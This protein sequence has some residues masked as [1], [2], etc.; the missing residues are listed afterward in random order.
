MNRALLFAG[1]GAQA[2]G[3]GKELAE[4]YPSCRALFDEASDVLGYDLATLC[5]EGPEDL[6]TRSDHAQPA[7]FVMSAASFLALEQKVANPVFSVSAGLS[8]GEWTALYAAGVLSFSDTVSLLQARGRFMQ[9]ACEEEPGGMLTLIGL[10][11]PQVMTIAEASGLEVANL[12][13]PVQTVLSGRKEYIPVAEQ[14][15]REAGAKR[16]LP[17]NVAGAFHSSL[18]QSAADQLASFMEQIVFS[19]PTRP[20]ISNVTAQPHTEPAEMKKQM[21]AQVTSSVRWVESV[22]TMQQAGVTSY[23]ECGPGKVLSGLVKRIDK[24]SS[25]HNIQD[26]SSLEKASASW[27]E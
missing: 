19:A 6:L 21:I 5:F 20:V 14:L 24:Q 11:L 2:V 18:M 16:A 7:I 15:A 22:E 12:N 17:L 9:E 23:V 27:A 3:M 13:S 8:L 1:Q 4:A 26:L 10:D 25:L